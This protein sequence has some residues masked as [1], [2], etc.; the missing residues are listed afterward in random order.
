MT[1]IDVLFTSLVFPGLLFSVAMAFWFQYLERKIVARIQR[2]IGPLYTGPHGL[3]QPL[4]DFLK[5]LFKEEIIPENTDK[6]YYRI[7]PI[8]VVAIPIYG[9]ALIPIICYKCTLSFEGDFLFTLFLF[10]LS[11]F[12]TAIA[13]YAVYS[14]YSSVGVG[15]LIVQYSIYESFLA[16]SLAIAALQTSIIDFSG[17]LQYQSIHG[18]LVFYQPIGFVVAIIALIAK[19]E[20]PPFDLPHAKQ[21]IV[22]G[23]MTEYSGRGLAFLKLSKDLSMVWGIALIST[24]YLGGPLG[25]LFPEAG[26][27]G[28][29]W[30]AI[31]C[32]AIS[33]VI[34]FVRAVSGRTR[35]YGLAERLWTRVIPLV[36]L[37]FIIA[38]LVRWYM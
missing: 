17:L 34:I 18:P 3:Y 32:L 31:K 13:G 30:F 7:A 12:T 29:L 8:L 21:E 10:S 2:R 5:M 9:M 22:A 15:R 4:Y 20:K 6:L 16:L 1:G 19:L 24:V 28:L 26:L 25:P 37:Q 33:L 36:V 35:V 27:V 14:P 38:V 23:W 11:V